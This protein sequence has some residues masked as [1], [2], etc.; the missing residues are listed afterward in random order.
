M[1]ESPLYQ[2]IV[3]EARREGATETTR[4]PILRALRNRFGDEA[5]DLKIDLDAVGYDRLE[6]LFDQA[7]IGP[8][9]ADS[10]ERLLSS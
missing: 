4:K 6:D 2:E 1:I 8:N 9:L 10:R 5:E 3:E 7:T